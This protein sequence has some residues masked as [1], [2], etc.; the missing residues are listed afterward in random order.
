MSLTRDERKLIHQKSKQPTF[1]VGKPDKNS[2]NEGDISFRKVEGSGTVQYLK[3]DGNWIALSSSGNLPQQ[4]PIGRRPS[5]LT[6]NNVIDHSSLQGLGSDDHSQYLL[7]DGSRA[8]SGNLNMAT[9]D[10]GSV[11]TL[12]V[13]GH[14]KLDRT[15]I[16]TAD[17]EFLASGANPIT[18]TT[19]GS[20][21]INLTSGN[22]LDVGVGLDY[23]LDVV[24][25]CD[26]NTVVTD[27]DNS[28][29]F[30]LTSLANITIETDGTDGDSSGND[31]SSNTI[32]IKNANSNNSDFTGIHIKTDS[33]G[34]GSA[35]NGILIECDNVAGK[36]GTA[37]V[38][39]RSENGIRLRA[40]NDNTGG[41][42]GLLMRATGPID[43]GVGSSLTPHTSD[44]RVKIHGLCEIS[45]LYNS[46]SDTID[47][48]THSVKFDQ[49]DTNHLVRA[50][51]YKASGSS[52]S[53]G[54]TFTIVSAGNDD[55]G[56]GTVWLV[57]IVWHHG[58]LND[59][60]QSYICFGVS[61]TALT[62]TLVAQELSTDAGGSL[63]WTSSSGIVFR[64][65][66][67]S[68]GSITT[69]KASALRLQSKDDFL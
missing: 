21:D 40:E 18:F 69:L 64:N 11:D 17:G 27:W 2:G 60:M 30:T 5:S 8:M 68:S 29:T 63:S 6:S 50:Q 4:R 3:Q 57:T 65:D 47:C 34:A 51:T 33:Q 25:T 20:N 43:I 24:R 62:A 14:T 61:T 12:D 67:S 23:E 44:S 49:I 45:R 56:L 32:L 7:V 54:S 22:T 36:G 26:W 10:I 15:T 53:A 16:D 38:D 19:T 1:G 66:H 42:T 59:C 13:D 46:G 55:N 41:S 28:S 58:T 39:V 37:G 35:F 31:D 9:N 52:I 48:S